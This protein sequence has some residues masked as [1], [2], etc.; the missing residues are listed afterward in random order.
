M[1]FIVEY[2]YLLNWTWPFDL[3]SSLFVPGWIC[4]D[5]CRYQCMWTTVGL[6]QAEGYKVPQFHGKVGNSYRGQYVNHTELR[7]NVKQLLILS[8][9]RTKLSYV[10][11]SV[12][13]FILIDFSHMWN[14]KWCISSLT[15]AICALPVFWGASVCPGLSA[16]R[17][18]LPS[19]AAALSEN[20]AAPEPHVPHHQRLL[21]G[22][23]EKNE[24]TNKYR[25]CLHSWQNVLCVFNKSMCVFLQVSLNAW[26]WSTV[27]HTRDTYLTEVMLADVTT[28]RIIGL[29]SFLWPTCEQSRNRAAWASFQSCLSHYSAAVWSTYSWEY[30]LFSQ[31][32][33]W[34]QLFIWRVGESRWDSICR[35]ANQNNELSTARSDL[36]T[37]QA[38]SWFSVHFKKCTSWCSFIVNR[39]ESC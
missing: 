29:S 21:S 39:M 28:K 23:M 37:L 24:N 26:F 3:C 8:I 12:F 33:S 16:Q 4:R 25:M 38:V 10:L 1:Y 36:F 7:Y 32:V 22:E 35:P 34:Q 5:D 11:Q 31:L 17:P 2:S 27:F 20:G 18:G 9:R 13:G 15:V 19:H 30:Y 14:Y 6:Y